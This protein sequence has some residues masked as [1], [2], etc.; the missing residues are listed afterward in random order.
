MS[1]NNVHTEQMMFAELST[2]AKTHPCASYAVPSSKRN[3]VWVCVGNAQ[4]F[5]F[6]QPLRSIVAVGKDT[7][8]DKQRHPTDQSSCQAKRKRRRQ[9]PE[10]TNTAFDHTVAF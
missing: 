4:K 5:V 8:G 6:G 2:Q 10:R 9:K 7:M 1:R 3:N